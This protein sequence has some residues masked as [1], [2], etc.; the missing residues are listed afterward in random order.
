MTHIAY[1]HLPPYTTVLLPQ[2]IPKTETKNEQ[3]TQKHMPHSHSYSYSYLY[4]YVRTWA[5]SAPRF[6]SSKQFF[7]GLTNKYYS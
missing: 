2:K 5:L 3:K 6:L 7:W 1:P 4:S